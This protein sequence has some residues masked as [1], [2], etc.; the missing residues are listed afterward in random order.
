VRETQVQTEHL[1]L[2]FTQ[3]Q[4][5]VATGNR[6][7]LIAELTM[8]EKMHVYAPGAMGYRPVALTIED[9]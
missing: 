8:P 2:T 5:K 4:A 1:R 3:T 9:I 6:V 7:T